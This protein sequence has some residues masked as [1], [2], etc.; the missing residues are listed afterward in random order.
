LQAVNRALA[1]AVD[2]GRIP[3]VVAAVSSS[4][5]CLYQA[6]FGA[7]A[8]DPYRPMAADSIFSIASMTKLVTSCAIMILVDEGK[9][10]LDAPLADYLPGF[11][12]PD[13]LVEF[14]AATGRYTT[15]P[16]AR[17]ATIRELLSHTGGY[18]YW[19][20][21]EPLRAASGPLPDLFS[22]PFLIADPG[23]RFR[24]STSADVVG[25]LVEP[26]AGLPLDAFF[27][28]RLFSPLGMPDTGFRRPADP[29]RVARVH[30]R[31]GQSFRQLPL[32]ELDNDV[33][34]GGGLYSTAV[35]YS[36]LL[37]CL[38]QG[39]ELDGIRLLSDRAVG[40]ITRNQIGDCMADMQR[41]ALVDRSNDF[42]F[43]N[44]TQ[45]FGFGV[46]VETEKRPGKRSVGSYGWG[47]IFNTYFWV[48]P[49]RDLAAVLM[50]QLAPFAGRASIEVLDEFEVAVYEDW[51]QEKTA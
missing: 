8:T 4:D 33:R 47:G 40:E 6:A 39:G 37:R 49:A 31:S 3:G 1:G 43:M 7:A 41:T 45:K 38:M 18:G 25:Q 12:Q 22:P 15:R 30:R 9:V 29:A 19:F 51:M 10:Q 34:G 46:M 20:L 24:Y 26:V 2:A 36:R 14:D 21:D 13:V 17:P 27:E 44:G 32:D 42:V 23:T 5:A 48:D 28:T 35:D 16:S 50:M 11:V